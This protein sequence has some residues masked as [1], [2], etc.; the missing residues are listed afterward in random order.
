MSASV[1]GAS[2]CQLQRESPCKRRKRVYV[3]Y[4]SMYG[5]IYKMAKSIVAGLERAGGLI[6]FI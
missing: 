5:H 2:L 3:I 6:S 1:P 4:Y